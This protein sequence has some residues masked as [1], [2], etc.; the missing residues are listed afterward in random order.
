[1][2]LPVMFVMLS[3]SVRVPM[4]KL[5]QHTSSSLPKSQQGPGYAHPRFSSYPPRFKYGSLLVR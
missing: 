2:L 3:A 1:V 5:E 4:D